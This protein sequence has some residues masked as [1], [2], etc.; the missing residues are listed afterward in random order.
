[1]RLRNM[2]SRPGNTVEKWDGETESWVL[3]TKKKIQPRKCLRCEKSFERDSP[4]LATCP[5]CR[6]LNAREQGDSYRISFA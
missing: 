5:S 1:M 6:E 3:V 4:F 2:K